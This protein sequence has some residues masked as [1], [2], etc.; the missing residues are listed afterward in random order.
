MVCITRKVR[1]FDILTNSVGEDEFANHEVTLKSLLNESFIS[2]E[3]AIDSTISSS[4]PAISTLVIL[5]TGVSP[6]ILYPPLKCD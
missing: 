1:Y 4:G 6:D 5:A 2:T 3:T